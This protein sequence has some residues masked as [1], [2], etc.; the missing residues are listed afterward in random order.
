MIWRS[1]K[2]VLKRFERPAGLRR[3]RRI[4]LTAGD[5]LVPVDPFC[6]W[7]LSLPD[8]PTAVVFGDDHVALLATAALEKR[9]VRIP[10]DISVVGFDDSPFASHG[11]GLT[12]IHQPARE[13]GHN[14]AEIVVKLI[15]GENT[16]GCHVQLPVELKVRHTTA[17]PKQRR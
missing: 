16:N 8:T 12:T 2:P 13:I 5:Y 3:V 15:R 17:P 14:A 10:E 6:D 7:F 1:G 11:R 4:G 9:G